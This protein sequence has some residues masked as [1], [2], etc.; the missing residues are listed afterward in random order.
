MIINNSRSIVGRKKKKEISGINGRIDF[1]VINLY[2]SL[3][4]TH[5]CTAGDEETG[6]TENRNRSLIIPQLVSKYL[7]NGNMYV[8]RK[9]ISIYT[10]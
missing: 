5:L 10:L 7:G 8:F 2:A 6:K 3:I 1:L 4:Y 9:K